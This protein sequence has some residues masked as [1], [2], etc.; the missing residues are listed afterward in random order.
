MLQISS[1]LLRNHDREES[2]ELLFLSEKKFSYNVFNSGMLLMSSSLKV[3][4][5]N[6]KKAA[7]V[8]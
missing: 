5:Q 3:I 8:I 7:T 6:E 2:V 4:V 1:A